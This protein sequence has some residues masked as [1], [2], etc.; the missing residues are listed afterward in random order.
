MLPISLFET[1]GGSLYGYHG[2]FS[3]RCVK[4]TLENHLQEGE[5]ISA[6]GF[7]WETV[8]HGGNMAGASGGQDVW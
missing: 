7:K 5:L 4:L 2:Y 3:H 8:Y 6:P 1:L